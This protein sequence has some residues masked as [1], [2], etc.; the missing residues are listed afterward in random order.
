MPIIPSVFQPIKQNDVQRRPIKAYKRYKLLNTDLAT[1]SSGYFRHR[2]VYRDHVPHIFSDTGQGVGSR[3]F[4]VNVLDNT[5]EHIVW[6]W[7]LL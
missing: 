7:D 3:V 2:A 5:N 1:T 6:K 4:P